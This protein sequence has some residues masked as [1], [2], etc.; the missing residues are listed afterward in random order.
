MF[1]VCVHRNHS[2][3]RRSLSHTGSGSVAL[4]SDELARRSDR[5]L[6]SRWSALPRRYAPTSCTG[7]PSER[8]LAISGRV[9]HGSSPMRTACMSARSAPHPPPL[10][11]SSSAH[12]T[13][14][15]S[16]ASTR[17]RHNPARSTWTTLGQPMSQVPGVSSHRRFAS[18]TAPLAAM[19]ANAALSVGAHLPV[20][21]LSVLSGAF[22]VCGLPLLGRPRPFF[23]AIGI[24]LLLMYGG[25]SPPIVQP[26]CPNLS[27]IGAGRNG[28]ST[29]WTPRMLVR[30][31]CAA[32]PPTHGKRVRGRRSE[33]GSEWR[34]LSPPISERARGVLPESLRIHLSGDL[35]YL[36]RA[37]CPP[38]MPQEGGRVRQHRVL[39]RGLPR[40][41]GHRDGSWRRSSPSRPPRELSSGALHGALADVIPCGKNADVDRI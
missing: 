23:R 29:S 21:Q 8:M 2:R 36:P 1:C 41:R 31:L 24:V 3:F 27:D 12:M 40:W 6:I 18:S 32:Q 15:V 25:A 30:V 13:E 16:Q 4:A 35:G 9:R 33:R 10:P 7:L 37:L 26:R 38:R 11:V 5:L 20:S 39:A 14:K 34:A 17:N 22:V 19:C 28:A